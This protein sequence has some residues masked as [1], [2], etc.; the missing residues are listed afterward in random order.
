MPMVF[1]KN[2][3][4]LSFNPGSLFRS[5]RLKVSPPVH[6][7]YV[8]ENVSEYI[9]ISGTVPKNDFTAK[10]N[11]L[12]FRTTYFENLHQG[13]FSVNPQHSIFA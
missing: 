1:A 4:Q 8:C 13:I 11:D 2:D 6:S 7:L 10:S 9:C 12:A 3:A 5:F